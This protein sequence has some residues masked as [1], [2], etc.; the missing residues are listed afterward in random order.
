MA[1][2]RFD[3]F[4]FCAARVV[5][6]VVLDL[7]PLEHEAD[8]SVGKVEAR[9]HLGVTFVRAITQSDKTAETLSAIV[10]IVV[11]TFVEIGLAGVGMHQVVLFEQYY[12]GFRH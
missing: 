6:V 5:S 9:S 7:G 8:G 10:E 4:E 11:C 1:L 2:E 3:D 12:F